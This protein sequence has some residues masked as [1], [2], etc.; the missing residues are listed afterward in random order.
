MEQKEV[1]LSIDNNKYEIALIEFFS[2]LLIV[3][4][5]F[6]TRYLM[7]VLAIVQCCYILQKKD[8]QCCIALFFFMLPFS[9]IYNLGSSSMLLLLKI[10]FIV[11]Y[12]LH[13]KLIR[14]NVFL[15][16]SVFAV[17]SLAGIAFGSCGMT[18]IMRLINILLWTLTCYIFVKSI[19]EDSFI[20]I[21]KNFVRALLV[22]GLVALVSDYIPGM[23]DMLTSTTI[24][25]T[26][27]R[28]SGLWNDPNTFSVFMGIG[29][30]I[31]FLFYSYRIIKVREFSIYAIALSILSLLSFSKMCLFIVMLIWMAMLFINKKINW[32]QKFIIIACIVLLIFTVY[33]YASDILNVYMLRFLK[34]SASGYSLDSLTTNRYSLWISYIQSLNDNWISWLVG[35]GMGC[36][37]PGGRAAHQTILQIIYNIGIIGFILWM[38]M[39]CSVLKDIRFL[40]NKKD[41]AINIT[42]KM[43]SIFPLL[44][45]IVSTM[46]LDY[47]FIESTYFLI[48]LS[49]MIYVGLINW[50]AS[51]E[52]ME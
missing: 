48:F 43:I 35:N 1:T 28:F 26:E 31:V 52:Y 17:Y 45:F 41:T 50:N 9:N 20:L 27:R 36:E 4:A 6:T 8:M 21:G 40:Y 2:V 38:A 22:A 42:T 7:L 44:I 46:F 16:I 23:K 13:S 25:M 30:S 51:W 15:S 18:G 12:F 19:E 14:T 29:L 33:Y 47:F 37:L 10:A 32:V 11:R 49:G 24:N 5:F 3:S 34:D 39:I